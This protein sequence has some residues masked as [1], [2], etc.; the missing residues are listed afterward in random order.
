MN[1]RALNLSHN[2]REVDEDGATR[3]KQAAFDCDQCKAEPACYGGEEGLFCTF[4]WQAMSAT[5]VPRELWSSN[6]GNA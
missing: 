4:C 6:G 1:R 5:S 3:V 2:R